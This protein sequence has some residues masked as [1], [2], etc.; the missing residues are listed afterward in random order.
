VG[1]PVE[2][3]PEKYKES[4]HAKTK[5]EGKKA[6][7]C[8]DCHGIHNVR[9]HEYTLSFIY[10]KNIHKTRGRCHKKELEEYM[11]SIHYKAAKKGI[12]EAAVC[13]DC[14]REHSEF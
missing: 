12:L 7:E 5:E 10:K 14:H 3:M 11:I 2:E 13:N 8:Y 4:I 6:P 1:A 9:S